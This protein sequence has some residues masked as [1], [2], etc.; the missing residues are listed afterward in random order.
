MTP[1]L[2]SR[3]AN[4]NS[5]RDIRVFNQQVTP[6]VRWRIFPIVITYVGHNGPSEPIQLRAA[7]HLVGL[8]ERLFIS[9]DYE[10]D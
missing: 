4:K 7:D 9:I 6:F 1:P 10:P 8:G 2:Y 3:P 5:L